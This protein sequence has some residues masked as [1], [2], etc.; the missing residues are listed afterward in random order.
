MFPTALFHEEQPLG[1]NKIALILPVGGI[2]IVL[3]FAWAMYQQLVVGKPFGDEPM[4]DT[5]LF[6]FG[7][8]YMLLGFALILLFYKGGL[9]TE[10]R[11]EGLFVRFAP[12]HRRFKHYRVDDLA[13]YE[14]V[15]YRPIRDFGGWGIRVASRGW[16]YNVSGNR[17]VQ[18]RFKSG[19]RLMIGSRRPEALVEAIRSIAR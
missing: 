16:V 9:T 4:S 7:L 18:L 17:G 19:K 1:D 2:L 12:F 11:P 3:F 13:E 6:Y 10:V 5:L 8:F 15:T 14:A